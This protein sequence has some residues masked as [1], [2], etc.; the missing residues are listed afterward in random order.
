MKDQFVPIKNARRFQQAVDRIHHKLKGIERM[1]LFFGDPGL[2]K[3]ETA[4]H[5]AA[6]N[7]SLYIRMKKLMT[8]RWF[9]TELVEDLG[10]APSWRTKDL[11]QQASDL[12]R[13]KKKTL[14][15]D[16]VDYFTSDTKITETLRDIHDITGT[17][18][19]FIGM[20]K[21]DQRL[22]RYPHLYDRFVEVVKFEPL[23]REDVEL[24][25]NEVSD[26]RFESDA[27]DKITKDSEGKIRRIISTIHKAEAIARANRAKTIGA[28][29]LR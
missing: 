12:L 5:Y 13:S 7:G 8:A 17:P 18:M 26:V 24:M 11:F 16:E 15:L 3:T 10:A 1:A 21:A 29:D 28:K 4:L 2:G 9:L 19:V 6:N 27:I 20:S 22:M 23:D 25:I 14:I